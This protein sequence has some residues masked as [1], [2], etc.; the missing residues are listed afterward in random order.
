M[1]A[2]AT[3]VGVA[4]FMAVVVGGVAFFVYRRILRRAKAIE[5]GIKMVPIR[6]HLPPPG[7]EGEESDPRTVMR[8]K[9]A[10]AETLYSLLAGAT[11]KGAS[12]AIY[13]QRHISLEIVA[14]DGTIHFFMAVPVALVP[15]AEQAIQSAY[16]TARLEE[17]EDYNIFSEQGKL[18][19]TT[20]G[21][22]I[23]QQPYSY[24]VMTYAELENDPMQAL[25]H[26]LSQLKAGEGA[27]VQIMVRPADKS[28]SNAVNKLAAQKRKSPGSTSLKITPKDLAKAAIKSPKSADPASP[29]AAIE[30]PQLTGIDEAIISSIEEKAKH[31]GFETLIRVLASSPD[32]TRAQGLL[33][34]MVSAFS[35]Y[36]APGRNGFKMISAGNIS[37]LV[38]AFIFRF[39]PPELRS[40][41]LNTQELATLFHLPDAEA[42]P[43]SQVERQQFQEADSPV[44]LPTEGLLFGYNQFRGV[45]KEVRLSTNDRRRH[46]YIVGQTGTGKSTMLENLAVQDMLA[47]RGFAF[48]DP[49]GDTA[50]RLLS[51][52]PKARAED[53][54]YFNPGDVER[55]LGLNLFE[56]SSPEQKDF[57]IQET[58][59]MLYKIYDPGKTGII[60]PRFEQWFRNAALTL[61]SDPAGSTFIEIPK[62][63]TDS[64]Y[65]KQKFKYLQD[66][67]VIEFWTKEM[68]QT[69]DFHKS[70]MLG[71][72]SSKFG[73]FLQNEMMRNIIG[74]TKSAF[75]FREIMDQNKILIVN[76]SKG[77]LGELNANLIG[78]IFVIKFQAAAMSR[79][80][81]PEDQRNDFCLYVDEFQNFS[82]DSFATILSEARKY[83]LNLIVANQFISQL[84]EEIRT[85]VFG[86]VGSVVSFRTGPEDADFL[87]KQF[88]PIFDSHDLVNIPNYNAVIRLMVGGLPSQ[89]FSLR[90]LPP[91]TVSNPELG[92]AIKQLSA[93][94]FGSSKNQVAAEITARLQGHTPEPPSVAAEP[95]AG[96]ASANS[97]PA[98]DLLDIKPL[99]PPKA[100]SVPQATPPEPVAKP[101]IA[102]PAPVAKTEI[103]PPEPV[104]ASSN[105]QIPAKPIQAQPTAPM[106]PKPQ[107]QA[108]SQPTPSPVQAP[109]AAT[110]TPEPQ[111]APTP[112]LQPGQIHVDEHGNVTQG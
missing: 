79:A 36:E 70:E 64:E 65:L 4:V 59:N 80:Q 111:L 71:W 45:Q 46:T 3:G 42:T 67:T 18:K 88:A 34:Q 12:T 73:A 24:P 28:W 97:E 103:S 101:N 109:A 69:S 30:T 84:S 58:I 32:N 49:H 31:P 22:L 25:L 89:P 66:Q 54:V 15:V 39:F 110:K 107:P 68:A 85:A 37:G 99:V 10:Q 102:A 56:F 62:V 61:M 106:A 5:R 48:I 41:I 108:P 75:N 26:T 52:V 57:I 11:K 40:Q 20:G 27:A 38:T 43:T 92:E 60:G 6:I 100:A 9:I 95:Q 77:L 53:I 47:G 17:V 23:L 74:Q 63:F 14:T 55:P 13:G 8:Q 90:A 7:N 33:T 93:A 50:E 16:P 104:S 91:L 83:R 112:K 51:V 78:M 81:V 1:S 21:E 19:G 96:Q 86:N 72:F 35:L 82:T 2:I 76:L 94:K 44:N 105:P 87:V 29:A 98:A